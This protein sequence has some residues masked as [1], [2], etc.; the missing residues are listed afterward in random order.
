MGLMDHVFNIL[1][2]L[3]TKIVEKDETSKFYRW[4]EQTTSNKTLFLE[5]KRFKYIWEN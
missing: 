1:M 5:E 3:T 2:I 4:G